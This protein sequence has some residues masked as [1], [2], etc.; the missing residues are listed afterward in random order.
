MA[1]ALDR[2]RGRNML[3]D[4]GSALGGMLALAIIFMG[5]RYLLDPTPAAAGF[6]IPG[7]RSSTVPDR[8]WLA[9]KAVCD[10]AIGIALVALLIDGAHRQLGYLLLATATVP[11]A[12]GTIVLRSGGPK[13]TAFMV[14]WGTAAVM[15]IV[16][17]LLLA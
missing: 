7:V 3:S 17:A 6:G 13:A 12:D 16:A 10:I 9:V 1:A 14:H 2:P 11:M 15:L 8:A 5:A 4:V